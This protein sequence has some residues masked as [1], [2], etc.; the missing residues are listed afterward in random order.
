M[1]LILHVFAPLANRV[2]GVASDLYQT[3]GFEETVRMEHITNQGYYQGEITAG[4]P[5]VDFDAPHDRD[6][7]PSEEPTLRT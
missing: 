5:D 4:G 6:Q 3:P 2:V 1:N 7:L